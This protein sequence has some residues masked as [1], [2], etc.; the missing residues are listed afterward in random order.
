MQQISTV[1][2]MKKLQMHMFL[3][4]L[5]ISRFNCYALLQVTTWPLLI[6]VNNMY[7]LGPFHL[8]HETFFKLLSLK[9]VHIIKV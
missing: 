3:F 9:N 5:C 6:L 1:P 4:P 8:G 2:Q 7:E